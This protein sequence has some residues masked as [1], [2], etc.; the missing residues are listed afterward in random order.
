[1]LPGEQVGTRYPSSPDRPSGHPARCPSSSHRKPQQRFFCWSDQKRKTPHPPFSGPVSQI[2]S[3]FR[4]P[5][6]PTSVPPTHPPTHRHHVGI[7][8]HADCRYDEQVFACTPYGFEYSN[9]QRPSR[10]PEGEADGRKEDDTS[11]QR[12]KRLGLWDFRAAQEPGRLKG[13]RV[14]HGYLQAS[15]VARRQNWRCEYPMLCALHSAGLHFLF[16][17]CSHPRGRQTGQIRDP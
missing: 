9:C 4:D 11:D 10:H 12:T 5:A 7:N 8:G 14:V 2:G 6:P 13:A 3:S 17:Y 1:M 15:S 16:G